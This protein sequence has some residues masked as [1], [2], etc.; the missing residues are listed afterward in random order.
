M[1]LNELRN[2]LKEKGLVYGSRNVVSKLKSGKLKRV[3]L[4]HNCKEELARDVERYA[5][6][7]KV[8]VIKLDKNNQEVG[9]LCKK[10]FAIS[11]LGY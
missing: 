7:N 9:V 4:A 3:F 2:A 11:V 8:E 1:S 5:K 10:P 6:L